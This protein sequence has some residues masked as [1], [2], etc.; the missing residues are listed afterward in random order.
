MNKY[1]CPIIN[2]M[3]N[4]MFNRKGEM[5]YHP[6]PFFYFLIKILKVNLFI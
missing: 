1:K 4:R 5:N 2:I 6:P 3:L